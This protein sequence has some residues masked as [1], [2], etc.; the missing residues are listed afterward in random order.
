MFVMIVSVT[1]IES[2]ACSDCQCDVECNR[3]LVIHVSTQLIIGEQCL[4]SFTYMVI[5]EPPCSIVRHMSWSC[6]RSFTEEGGDN[7]DDSVTMQ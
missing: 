1:W 3:M 7:H 4:T 5:Y 2:Y 6:T